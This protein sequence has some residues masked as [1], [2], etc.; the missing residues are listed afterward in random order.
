MTDFLDLLTIGEA[1]IDM[2]STAPV[3]SPGEAISFERLAGGSPANIAIN[4][5]R[6]GFKSALIARVG[7][8]P[9]GL[10]IKKNLE[11]YDVHLQG[12]QVDPRQKT[13]VI[14]IARGLSNPKVSHYR[15]ADRY[16]AFT[17]KGRELVE[18]AKIVHFSGFTL[19]STR[20]RKAMQEMKRE[21]LLREKVLAFD[22]CFHEPL[23]RDPKRGRILFKEFIKDFYLLKPSL[24]DMRRLF[25]PISPEEGIEYYHELGAKNIVLTMGEEGVLFFDGETLSHLKGEEREPMDVTGAGDSFWSG[26]YAGL[27]KGLSLHDSIQLGMKVAEITIMH[28]GAIAPLPP[29]QEILD[30][31]KRSLV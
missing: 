18:K 14:F 4:M 24:E 25:G 23:W 30:S 12:L 3:A 29:F 1:L 7:E 17:E 6:L 28:L 2:I 26:L 22:P 31:S 10:F 8:D 13:S 21:A 19:S 20:A 5:A 15:M 27:L 11:S 16:L 9:F